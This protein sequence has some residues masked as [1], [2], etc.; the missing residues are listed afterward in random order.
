MIAVWVCIATERGSLAR[1]DFESPI[2]RKS[3]GFGLG[4]DPM[5]KSVCVTWLPNQFADA[6]VMHTADRSSRDSMVFVVLMFHSSI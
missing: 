5:F 1:A 3:A 2:A 4:A 6:G